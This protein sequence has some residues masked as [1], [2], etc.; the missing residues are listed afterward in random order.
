MY[1]LVLFTLLTMMYIYPRREVD[2]L[3]VFKERAYK[4]SGIDP[5]TYAKFRIGLS[6]MQQS[7]HS[8]D[9]S[10][11]Y[12]YGAIDNLQ[13]LGLYMKGGSSDVVYEIHQLASD[14]GDAG[15]R[16]LL[17]EALAQGVRFMPKYLKEY[18]T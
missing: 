18:H 16:M 14:I 5:D 4:Y 15:E 9:T 10:A 1:L 3:Q 6:L 17:D 7:I 13:D 11:S 8:V 2:R 12:L